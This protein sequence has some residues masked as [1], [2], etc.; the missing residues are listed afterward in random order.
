MGAPT[1]RNRHVGH[2]V[3][4]RLWREAGGTGIYGGEGWW[5]SPG[6]RGDVWS[7]AQAA[8][9]KAYAG[10]RAESHRHGHELPADSVGREAGASG[11]GRGRQDEP[12]A[13]GDL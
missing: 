13:A 3:N 6:R 10:G 12:E 5:V 9:G 1:A 8:L 2:P 7:G 11:D 4:G